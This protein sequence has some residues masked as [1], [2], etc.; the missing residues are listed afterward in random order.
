MKKYIKTFISLLIVLIIIGGVIF[1]FYNHNKLEDGFASLNSNNWPELIKKKDDISNIIKSYLISTYGDGKIVN[2]ENLELYHPE[3]D[4]SYIQVNY[5]DN[6][7]I[8]DKVDNQLFIFKSD[9][10]DGNIDTN[11][12]YSNEAT[13]IEK[14]DMKTLEKINQLLNTFAKVYQKYNFITYKAEQFPNSTDDNSTNL[15]V[16]RDDG[17][18]Q[19]VTTYTKDD[20]TENM[21]LIILFFNNNIIGLAIQIN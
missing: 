11:I 8:A 12:D 13:H 4:K 5:K 20:M 19:F 17:F 1:N 18:S 3:D 16:R 6:I 2:I 7:Y 14:P 9:L 21:N 10:M 15:Y